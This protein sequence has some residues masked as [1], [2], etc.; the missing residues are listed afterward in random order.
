MRRSGADIEAMCKK[1]VML[2]LDECLTRDK[3]ADLGKCVVDPPNF[4]QATAQNSSHNDKSP[5]IR[6]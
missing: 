3:D 2:A 5:S 1:A 4:E 6:H